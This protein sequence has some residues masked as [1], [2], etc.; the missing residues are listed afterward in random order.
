[1]ILNLDELEVLYCRVISDIYSNK[2]GGKAPCV[3]RS[4]SESV[5]NEKSNII[6]NKII[7]FTIIMETHFRNKR[8]EH[9]R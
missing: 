2:I 6:K 4:V 5:D 9:V 8:W 3:L 7:T 1:M